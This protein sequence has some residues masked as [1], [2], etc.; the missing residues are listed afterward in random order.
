MPMWQPAVTSGSLVRPARVCRAAGVLVGVPALCPGGGPLPEDL[1]APA[2]VRAVRGEPCAAAGV[3]AGL[4][5]GYGRDRG[6][7]VHAGGRRR[8][9]GPPG[10]GKGG[11][12]IYDRPRLGPPVPGRRA[13]TRGAP[14]TGGCGRGARAGGRRFR[15][16]GVRASPGRRHDQ[17]MPVARGS[18]PVSHWLRR[19]APR[20]SGRRSPRRAGLRRTGGGRPRSRTG[21]G[22]T[23]SPAAGRAAG[24][25]PGR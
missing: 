6:R 21:Q 24:P 12:A 14:S 23:S 17:S 13:P 5:A 16:A 7:G 10:R 15:C 2:A 3:H 19:A 20:G 4:A 25:W 18:G 8:V 9:R 11:G 22:H 1:R